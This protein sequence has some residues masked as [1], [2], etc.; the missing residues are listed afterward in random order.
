MLQVPNPFNL[1]LSL[2][3]ATASASASPGK[4]GGGLWP[5]GGPCQHG[6]VYCC[7]YGQPVRASKIPFD[8]ISSQHPANTSCPIVPHSQ[9]LSG[10]RRLL[11]SFGARSTQEI[12]L[13]FS[14]ER[15]SA[16]TSDQ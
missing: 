13:S 5:V 16:L 3:T 8:M 10:H 1:D 14:K 9:S 11:C 2:F 4:R 15:S 7:P 12:F 6:N